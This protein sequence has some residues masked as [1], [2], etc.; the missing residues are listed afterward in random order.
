MFTIL[1][2]IALSLPTWTPFEF[3]TGDWIGEGSGDPGQGSGE[4]SFKVDLQG[5]VMIRKNIA[6]YPASTHDDLMV[7]YR[8]SPTGPVRADY[9]DNEGH[10]IRYA[11]TATEGSAQFLSDAAARTPRYRLTYKVT[12]KDTLSIQFE[13]APPDHPDVFKTYLTAGAHRKK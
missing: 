7:M 13:I 10:V 11:V 9:Y 3:L 4:F 6:R 5:A 2:A 12:G 1:L 8:E